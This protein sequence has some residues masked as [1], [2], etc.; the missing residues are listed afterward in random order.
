MYSVFRV[1]EKLSEGG[2]IKNLVLL[3][4]VDRKINM[5]RVLIAV[6]AMVVLF[7]LVAC[8]NKSDFQDE[9][10]V[11]DLTADDMKVVSEINA[12]SSLFCNLYEDMGEGREPY[13]VQAGEGSSI[14]AVRIPENT[15]VL[16]VKE[17]TLCDKEYNL[18]G[19]SIGVGQEDFE[20]E[21]LKRNYT[22]DKQH[23]SKNFR[24]ESFK[25]GNIYVAINYDE[26]LK[27]NRIFINLLVEY[28][29]WREVE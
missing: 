5:K 23:N 3:T 22:I 12:E 13:E 20:K 10:R 2:I 11:V 8:N 29:E 27:V 4:K 17:I 18:Y 24:Y 14:I 25:K 6:I 7:S 9:L 26:D 19:M 21:M 28:T 1:Q 16:R 15:G